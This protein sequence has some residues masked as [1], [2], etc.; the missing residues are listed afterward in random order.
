M[1]PL[2]DGYSAR[3]P[4][5]DDANAVARLIAACQLVDIGEAEMTTEELLDDWHDLELSEEAVVVLAPDDEPAG[6]ADV[7]NRGYVSIS[8]YG[9]VHPEHRER[10]IGSYLIGWG[11]EWANDRLRLA[12]EG[13]RVVIQHY[14]L[15]GSEDAHRLLEESGYA[16]LRGTYVMA[17]DMGEAPSQPEWPEEASVRTFQPGQDERIAHEAVEDAFRDVWGRPRGSLERFVRMTHTDGFDPALW[18]LAADGD[19]ISG[20]CL[21]KTVAGRGWVDVV[22]VRSP[23]RGRGLGLALLRHA[24]GEFYRRGVGRVEL[25]VDAESLTGAP[26]LYR[27]AGMRVTQTYILHQKELRPGEDLTVWVAEYTGEDQS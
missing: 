7:I 6:Y 16:P 17:I 3:A 26:R 21:C 15:A 2:P 22:G 18:F 14:I 9:Y 5:P 12:P 11:E 13:S 1:K 10:G 19:E 8:V 27:R 4:V 24:F 23:W 25:S 20:A